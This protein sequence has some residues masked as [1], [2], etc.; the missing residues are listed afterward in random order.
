ML[1]VSMFAIAVPASGQLRAQLVANGFAAPLA[2]VQDPSNPSVQIVVEQGGRFR[3]LLDGVVQENDFLDLRDI[4]LAGGESGVLG[5]AFAPDYAVSGRLFVFFVDLNGNSVISRFRRTDDP[6]RADPAS[7]FDFRWPGDTTALVPPFAN[8]KGGNLVFGPD[9]Y[10]YIAIGDGGSGD[11]PFNLAQNPGVFFGKILRLNVAVPDEDA[12]GYD[13]PPDNPFVANPD[14]LPHI[15]SLGLRNPWRWSFDDPARGGTGAMLLADVGQGALEEFNYEPAGAGGRNYGWRVREGNSDNILDP[16]PWSP[17]TEPIHTYD[18]HVGASITGGF[19]YRGSVLGSAYVGRYFFGD[20]ITG[21]IWSAGLNVDPTTHEATA[22]TIIDHSEELVEAASFVSSFGI[23]AAGEIYVV[24]YLDGAVYKIV[25]G[26][27][28]TGQIASALD[29]AVAGNHVLPFTVTG[30]AIDLGASSGVGIDAVHVFAAPV[31]GGDPIFLGAA[32]RYD[33]PDIAALHGSGF[34]HSG[35]TISVSGLS[36]GQYTIRTLLHSSVS[37]QVVDGPQALVVVLGQAMM[38]IT[39]AAQTGVPGR[40]SIEGWALDLAATSGTGVASVELW[41][42]RTGEPVR[43]LGLADYGTSRPD[44]AAIYGPAFEATG[45]TKQITDLPPGPWLIVAYLNSSLTGT[46]VQWATTNITMTD[47][48]FVRIEAPAGGATLPGG[49][50]FIAGWTF[51]LGS[52]SGI[53]VSAV[54][55]WATPH[56]GGAA[57]FLGTATLGYARAD[58]AGVL[59]MQFLPSGYALQFSLP[60]GQYDLKV[61]ALRASSG[62]FDASHTVTITIGGVP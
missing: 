29:T 20:F 58:I 61:E 13:I 32:T 37:D 10:L 19:V 33:R 47:G 46:R 24:S 44:V 3:V 1:V 26:T 9:G 39:A 17:L 60:P 43:F 25:R 14:V 56:G 18:H 53:G 8:H 41:A 11:D 5:L 6:L 16:G 38:A 45:W 40:L 36:P 52:G 23:D 59:G 2:F 4:A 7:R 51:D 28:N 34:L 35:F 49:S 31:A 27:N 50:Q 12:E 22:G 55:A 15:W 42:A 48:L 62:T 30:W 54:R 21:R 57:I